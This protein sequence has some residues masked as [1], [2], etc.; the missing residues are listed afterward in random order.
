MV[1]V[2]LNGIT[3]DIPTTWDDVTVQKQMKVEELSSNHSEEGSL[4]SDLKKQ[5]A[6]I[7]GYCGIPVDVVRTMQFG[8]MKDILG[9]L[10]FITIPLDTSPISKF[11]HRGI[12]YSVIPSLLKSEFQD[13][14]SLE[15]VLEMKKNRLHEALP[16]IISILAK[17]EVLNGSNQLAKQ[18]ESLS[19]FDIEE[20]AKTFMDLPITIASKLQSFFLTSGKLQSIGSE[21]LLQAQNQLI[22]AQIESILTTPKPQNT[23]GWLTRLLRGTLRLYLRFLKRNW[24]RLYYG[25]PLKTS[26]LKET[27]R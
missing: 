26:Q 2:N 15:S 23:G 24:K 13:F 11:E 25:L 16:L 27:I 21:Q 14:I 18:Y 8:Q 12:K 6:V 22:T 4:A 3:Y 5:I 19:D 17:R 10:K 7:S 1:H 20:R 9:H